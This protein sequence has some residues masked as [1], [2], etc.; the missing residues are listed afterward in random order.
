MS[1]EKSFFPFF[2]WPLSTS[3][4]VFYYLNITCPPAWGYCRVLVDLHGHPG[5]SLATKYLGFMCQPLS[6]LNLH[7]AHRCQETMPGRWGDG[8]K[9]CCA[10]TSVLLPLLTEHKFKNKI[11]RVLKMV[12]AALSPSVRPSSEFRALCDLTGGTLCW[13]WKKLGPSQDRRGMT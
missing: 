1:R 5:T 2:L 3:H 10:C 8:W 7:Q 9:H 12:S 13:S 11:I 6:S 4:G